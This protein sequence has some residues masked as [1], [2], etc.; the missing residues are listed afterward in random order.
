MSVVKVDKKQLN[1]LLYYIS[2][3]NRKYGLIFK[4]VYVYGRSIQEV[5]SLKCGDVDEHSIEFELPRERFNFI[6]DKRLGGDLL[7]YITGKDLGREDYIF[8]DNADYINKYSKNLNYYL[9]SIIGELNKT[10]FNRKC[11]SLVNSDL[12]NLRGQHLFLDGASVNVINELYRNRNI[13]TT[14][15]HIKYD[16]LLGYRDK[17]NSLDK[18]FKEYTDLRV[19][20]DNSF[21][22]RD[23]FLLV[24]DGC[25]DEVVFE[26]D[27]VDMVVNWVDKSNPFLVNVFEK[28][29]VDY[30][31]LKGLDVGDYLLFGDLRIIKN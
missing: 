25:G 2:K 5:L 31:L 21:D 15:N 30:D 20:H 19:F 29:C 1:E 26:L 12:R 28:K 13:Q 7:D 4:L 6:L 14:K 10:V 24:D 17:C 8:I 18:V 3:D 22:D 9:N 23:L 16:E 27:Y 11:P